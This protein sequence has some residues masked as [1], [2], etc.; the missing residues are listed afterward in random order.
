MQINE[1]QNRKVLPMGWSAE[2]ELFIA[3]IHQTESV[4]RP[5]ATS[6]FAVYDPDSIL[7]KDKGKS[8]PRP[9]SARIR[10]P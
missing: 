1:E 4:R 3:R 6:E 8:H 2:E 10:A 7:A 5:E 9:L